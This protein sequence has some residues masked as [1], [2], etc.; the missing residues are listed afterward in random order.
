MSKKK[1]DT[2]A[3]SSPGKK[4]NSLDK[5]TSFSSN[6][7]GKKREPTIIRDTTSMSQIELH[8]HNSVA[9]ESEWFL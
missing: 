7:N 3:A 6:I 8:A 4:S 2:D 5:I 9:I 1:L